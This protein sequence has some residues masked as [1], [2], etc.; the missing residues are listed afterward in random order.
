VTL[1]SILNDLRNYVNV[2]KQNIVCKMN[3]NPHHALVPE[4]DPIGSVPCFYRI[5]LVYAAAKWE[6]VLLWLIGMLE[7]IACA[8]GYRVQADPRYS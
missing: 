7:I 1:F 5:S 3:V 6:M 2:L 8:R 4:V